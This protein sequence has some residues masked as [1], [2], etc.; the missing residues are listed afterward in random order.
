MIDEVHNQSSIQCNIQYNIQYNVEPRDNYYVVHFSAMASPCE[1]LIDTSD[2]NLVETLADLGVR[3]VKRI[4]QKFSR[5]VNNNLCYNINNA[6]G[7]IVGIDDECYKLLSYADTCFD[8][9][10]GMFDLTSGVLRKA[11]TFDGSDRIP[12]QKSIDAVLPFIGWTKVSFDQSTI[13]MNP[14]MEID[15]GGVGKEYAVSLVAEQFRH[16]FPTVSCLINLGGDIQITR[17]RNDHQC[18]YVGIEN[19]VQA[20]ALKEGALATSGD[21]KRYLLKNGKRYSHILNPKTGWPILNGPASITVYSPL[22]VQA[23]SLA[24]L[25]LLHGIH[26]ED[27]LKEQDV[28]YWCTHS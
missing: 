4:E 6:N 5:Y 23:G 9:S 24:T 7:E 22:C 18:W 15:F 28:Q 19:S 11:W 1:F 27:F 2:E 21:A 10:D 13:Q 26:A 17:A 14:G 16:H 25:A 8:L 20:I 12:T 3:E